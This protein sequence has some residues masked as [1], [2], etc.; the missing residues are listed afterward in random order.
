MQT[1][2]SF[3]LRSVTPGAW[4]HR[5]HNGGVINTSNTAPG[6]RDTRSEA[7]LG[8][9]QIIKPMHSTKLLQKEALWYF[10]E[11]MAFDGGKGRMTFLQAF[12]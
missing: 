1:E 5:S 4:S 12:L 7:T 11:S 3:K 6:P 9:Y 2:Q 10:H 8:K